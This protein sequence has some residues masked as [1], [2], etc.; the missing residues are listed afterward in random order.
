MEAEKRGTFPRER[1]WRCQVQAAQGHE[2]LLGKIYR[3]WAYL[4][5]LLCRLLC[6]LVSR[7]LLGSGV[8][9]SFNRISRL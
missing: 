4:I 7:V 3:S 9:S 6:L 1:L 2:C 5:V 8:N